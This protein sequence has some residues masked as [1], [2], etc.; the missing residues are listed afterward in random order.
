MKNIEITTPFIKLDQLLKYAEVVN[1]GGFAKILISDGF[2]QVND[3]VCKMRG[4]KIKAGDNVR[5]M[6]PGENG[7]IEEVIELIVSEK[8]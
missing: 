1:T 7:N 2:V 5:I 3:D 4:K 8:V 6:I